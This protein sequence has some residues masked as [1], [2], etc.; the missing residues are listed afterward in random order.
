[1]TEAVNV[2]NEAS[3]VNPNLLKYP[4]FVLAVDAD[5]VKKIIKRTSSLE[6]FPVWYFLD[7]GGEFVWEE[8]DQKP[9]S[10]RVNAHLVIRQRQALEKNP[11]YLQLLPY[12]LFGY[13][14]DDGSVSMVTYHRKKGHGEERLEGAMS[15]GWGGHMDVADIAWKDNADIDLPLSIDNNIRRETPE[16][17]VFF[18]ILTG[19]EIDA[20]AI[21]ENNIQP[22]GYIYDDANDV[23]RVHLAIVSLVLLPKDVGVRKRENCHLDGPA[24]TVDEINRD[25]GLFEPWSQI[26]VK[27]HYEAIPRMQEN[28]EQ[29]ANALVELQ[30]HI[31][32]QHEQLEANGERV[33]QLLTGATDTL[34]CETEPQA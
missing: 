26:I 8:Q 31:V 9:N 6:P 13:K 25:L 1:M 11:D 7:G 32:K 24:M 14:Q 18:D 34:P 15:F 21:L 23:G 20:H 16:E 19:E 5:Y 28:M 3:K 27:S 12:T 33:A 17:M 29:A 2:N 30:N 22:L 4:E 10:H